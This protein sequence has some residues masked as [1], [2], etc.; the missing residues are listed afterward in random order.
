LVVVVV[1]PDD[2]VVVVAVGDHVR[3]HADDAPVDAGR[4]QGEAVAIVELLSMRDAGVTPP[5]GL[6]WLTLGLA[7]VFDKA[8]SG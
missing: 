7:Q 3:V 4:V 6:D 2:G 8:T 1:S 5:P